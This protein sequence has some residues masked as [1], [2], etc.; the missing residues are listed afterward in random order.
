MNTEPDDPLARAVAAG[1]DR[2]RAMMDRPP[3]ARPRPVTRKSYLAELEADVAAARER[4]YSDAEIAR[5]LSLD[6]DMLKTLNLDLGELSVT[7]RA[8]RRGG[9]DTRVA[10]S[11]SLKAKKEQVRAGSGSGRKTADPAAAKPKATPPV[12]E[13]AGTDHARAPTLERTASGPAPDRAVARIPTPGPMLDGPAA[14]DAKT[15]EKPAQ[16]APQV[17]KS[18]AVSAAA[19]AQDLFAAVPGSTARRGDLPMAELGRLARAVNRHV[20]VEDAEV[21]S[22]S[23][24][25]DPPPF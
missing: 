13:P 15:V 5:A 23:V 25:S 7:E 2:L 14:T 19:A 11:A 3:A 8:L 18:T 21:V 9:G 20:G 4:G 1:R 12:P 24:P 10:E 17:P 22:T 16:V 6:A